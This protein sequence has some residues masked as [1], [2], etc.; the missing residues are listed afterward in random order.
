MG[1]GVLFNKRTGEASMDALASFHAHVNQRQRGDC[2]NS[3][4]PPRTRTWVKAEDPSASSYLLAHSGYPGLRAPQPLHTG[5]P[6]TSGCPPPPSGGQLNILAPPPGFEPEPRPFLRGRLC[7]WAME[8]WPGGSLSL[9][10]PDAL[11]RR[12]CVRESRSRTGNLR[13]IRPSLCY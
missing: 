9:L 6:R 11:T 12:D 3:R 1:A 13:F 7:R 10:P 2:F 8:V 4:R 5:Y